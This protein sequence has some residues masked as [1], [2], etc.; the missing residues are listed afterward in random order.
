VAAPVERGSVDVDLNVNFNATLDVDVADD[1]QD[2]ASA[3]AADRAR[4]RILDGALLELSKRST[5]NGSGSPGSGDG[6][7]IASR[8][9]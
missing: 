2:I 8:R 6:Q 7:D 1:G 9:C 3:V 4:G 5:S